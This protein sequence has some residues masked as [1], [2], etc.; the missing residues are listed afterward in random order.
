MAYTYFPKFHFGCHFC[1]KAVVGVLVTFCDK[2]LV[3]AWHKKFRYGLKDVFDS[4]TSGRLCGGEDDRC[5]CCV[6]VALTVREIRF[7]TILSP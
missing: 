3:F 5:Q 6:V 4:P 1:D 2:S 7:S